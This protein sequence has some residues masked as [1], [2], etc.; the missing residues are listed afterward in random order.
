M[1]SGG[2]L[3]S[4]LSMMLREISDEIVERQAEKDKLLSRWVG[5][6]PWMQLSGPSQFVTVSVVQRLNSGSTT[7][8]VAIEQGNAFVELQKYSVRGWHMHACLANR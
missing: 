6:W 3:A 1:M 4:M 7:V 2:D 5:L 8:L